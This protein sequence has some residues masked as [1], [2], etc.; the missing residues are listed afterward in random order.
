MG[1]FV[2]KK[3][4]QKGTTFQAKFEYKNPNFQDA[5]SSE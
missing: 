2:Y 5:K 4:F 1:G 3:K